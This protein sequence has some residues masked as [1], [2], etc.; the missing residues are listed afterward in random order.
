M[1]SI[2]ELTGPLGGL[3]LKWAWNILHDGHLAQ[4]AVQNATIKAARALKSGTIPRNMQAW[5]RRTV[6]RAAI[7]LARRRLYHRRFGSELG[8][9]NIS[10]TAGAGVDETIEM[11]SALPPQDRGVL[12]SSAAGFTDSQTARLLCLSVPAVVGRLAR[13]RKRLAEQIA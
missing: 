4:D 2:D 3:A 7:D 1:N 8:L 13:A 9:L 11:L 12:L 10:A 5:F 6:I